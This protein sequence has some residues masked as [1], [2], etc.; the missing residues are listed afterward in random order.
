MGC[1]ATIKKDSAEIQKLA[2][3]A[4]GQTAVPWVRVYRLGKTIYFS[5][6]THHRK[7]KVDCV[8]CHGPVA[9]REVMAQE[10]SI[11]MTACM[12]CHDQY[13]ASN[14]CMLCHDSF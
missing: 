8:V 6:E 10:K 13:K 14:D 9:E 5:H 11:A 2:Q 1:H 4:A 12:A 3:F 7:A